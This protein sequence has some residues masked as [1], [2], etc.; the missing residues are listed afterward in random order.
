M[1]TFK[2]RQYTSEG[3]VVHTKTIGEGTTLYWRSESVQVMSDIW[4]WLPVAYYEEN[5]RIAQRILN[6]ETDTVVVDADIDAVCKRIFNNEYTRLYARESASLE[7]E[8]QNPAV[9]G[10]IV[11]VVSGRT[12]KGTVGKVVARTEKVYGMGYRSSLQYKLAI[13][14]DDEM[15]D[16]HHPNGK[17]YKNYKNLVWVWALNCEVVNPEVDYSAA[18]VLAQR[19]AEATVLA[20]RERFT[21]ALA[22]QAT[23]N[24]QKVAAA[25]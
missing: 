6:L 15:V 22:D 4:E 2:Y 9:K 18:E 7:H 16:Y 1:I 3:D 21:E 20:L 8:A 19:H 10:R 5:G 25:A 11:K 24:A 14:L 23:A 13:A 17:V 12:A